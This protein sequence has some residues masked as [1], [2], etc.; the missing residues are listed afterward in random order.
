MTLA[1]RKSL[2]VAAGLVAFMGVALPAS[3][4]SYMAASGPQSG[5]ISVDQYFFPWGADVYGQL[6]VAPGGAPGTKLLVAAD[7]SYWPQWTSTARVA[8]GTYAA[9]RYSTNQFFDWPAQYNIDCSD[10]VW[11]ILN[12]SKLC[13]AVDIPVVTAEQKDGFIAKLAAAGLRYNLVFPIRD[14]GNGRGYIVWT[15]MDGVNSGTMTG[16]NMPTYAGYARIDGV[17]WQ[18]QFQTASYYGSPRPFGDT[19]GAFING[20][21]SPRRETTL[22]LVTPMVSA[23]IGTTL[24]GFNA[25][26]VTDDWLAGTPTPPSPPP[27]LPPPPTVANKGANSI[28][29]GQSGSSAG[30][31]VGSSANAVGQGDAAFDMDAL[32]QG[33]HRQ[34]QTAVKFAEKG[35][36]RSP[37]A[38]A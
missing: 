33:L 2:M 12:N 11:I 32:G 3:A 17:G 8:P 34:P 31:G 9:P 20:L 36:S 35:A 15:S 26:M 19:A 10:N 38:P 37:L 23:T 14:N 27:Q 18:N 4:Q 24:N 29:I 25:T 28:N 30:F 7:L 6:Y 16:P 13:R 5:G 21:P 1:V 22:R